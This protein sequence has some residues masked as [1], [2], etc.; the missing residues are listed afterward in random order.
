[1]TAAADPLGALR[2]FLLANADVNTATG[3]RVRCLSLLAADVTAMPRACVLLKPAGGPGEPGGGYQQYG[4]TRIDVICYG[5]TEDESWDVYLA[6][7]AAL[8]ALQRVK[9][10]NVLLHSADVSS[11]GATALDPVKQWPVTYSSWLVLASEIAA[12]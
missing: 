2:T 9:A 5:A 1:M 3:G 11:K 4:K 12:P 7:A 8:K 6:A 10:A